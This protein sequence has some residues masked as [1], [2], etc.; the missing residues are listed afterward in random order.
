MMNNESVKNESV[1]KRTKKIIPV[2]QIC[3]ENLNKSTNIPIQC[4]YCQFEACRKCCETYATNE[5]R[6]KCMNT[7]C[8][9]EWTRKF[10]RESF[11]LMFING[12]LKEH[13]EQ[14]LFD[15]ERALL[16]ATQPII[17][18]K[19]ECAK[20]DTRIELMRNQVSKLTRE[21]SDLYIE[22]N[23]I[24]NNPRKTNQRTAFVRAC[25][26]ED[27]RG[28]LSSQWKCGIC[29]KWCCPDCHII[30]GFTRDAE[31]TCNEDDVAT[32]R[33]IANDTKPCP[34]CA[35]G[36]FK[37]D[38]CDQ[39]WCTQCHTAFS[40]RTGAIENNV[41]NPH[42][43]EWLRRTNG[44]EAPRNP[45]DIPCGRELNNNLT[46]MIGRCLR[47]RH[48][49]S[50]ISK[51]VSARCDN[52]IRNV[53]HLMR[54][55]EIRRP[56]NYER[57]NEELRVRYLMKEITENEMKEQL[58]R[59]DKRNNKNQ[60]IVDIY[61][62]VSTTITD[63]LY[64]FLHY[65]QHDCHPN[66]FST[67]ILDEIDPLITYANECLAELSH[68]YSS[69]KIVFS[70]NLHLLKGEH[71]VKYLREQREKAK[72]QTLNQTQTQTHTQTQTQ[73]QTQMQTQTLT[74]NPMHILREI[75]I[76]AQNE[77]PNPTQ[78]ENPIPIQNENPIPIQNENDNDNENQYLNETQ[79]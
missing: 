21:I 26:D 22:R 50:P 27:C 3:D 6:V 12:R 34:K 49:M 39:I 44:G 16:P 9:R 61:T 38:G 71:A 7:D 1:K 11:T 32:A 29:E 67:I 43:Y 79:P 10:I 17:E 52:I 76:Q 59:D 42:Y 53:I 66:E 64:R 4:E 40:W 60:E 55:G 70:P 48:H 33:L 28:F 20:I 18:A 57:R 14:L 73:T 63:I 19:I 47:T 72:T 75:L 54:G 56:E 41:H 5:S 69:A 23:I 78:N 36:I 24:N 74:E 35:T 31:H 65:L 62:M 13:R 45:G 46:V 58:Q 2:C 37:I 15:K 51:T 77:N 25:P 68:T 8:G 30:K